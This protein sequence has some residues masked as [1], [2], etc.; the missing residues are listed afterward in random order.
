MANVNMDMLKELQGLQIKSL[1]ERLRQDIE[2]NIPTDAATL[3]VIQKILKDNNCT[4]DP[5]EGDKLADLRKKLTEQRQQRVNN[6][7]QLAGADLKE[8]TG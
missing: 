8:A 7:I 4:V 6:V 3:G 5:A 2:D 1:M